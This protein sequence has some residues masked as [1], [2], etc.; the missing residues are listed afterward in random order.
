MYT[1]VQITGQFTAVRSDA[2]AGSPYAVAYGTPY[3]VTYEKL[4]FVWNDIVNPNEKYADDTFY[5]NYARVENKYT[6]RPA[7]KDYVLHITWEAKEA[8]SIAVDKPPRLP[9]ATM[10]PYS[11]FSRMLRLTEANSTFTL[12][13][14]HS[15]SS[16]SSIGRPEPVPCPISAMQERNVTVSSG[17]IT[18]Q[19]LTSLASGASS[20]Q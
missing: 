17:S 5:A 16:A 12:S 3:I 6:G 14:R 13:Q 2:T 1:D 9:A 11:V 4:H 20:P 10:S 19:A 18:T 7:P 8:T 15:S